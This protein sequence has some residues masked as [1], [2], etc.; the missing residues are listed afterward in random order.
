MESFQTHLQ[1]KKKLQLFIHMLEAWS[2]VII[3]PT[4]FFD[5]D[6]FEGQ[7]SFITQDNK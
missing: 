3:N 7:Q 1:R 5:F 4:Y 2:K 6:H